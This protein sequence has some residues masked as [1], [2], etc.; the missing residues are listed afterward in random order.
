MAGGR[1]R[2]RRRLGRKAKAAESSSLA[3][4]TLSP[5]EVAVVKM[6]SDKACHASGP[7]FS[8]SPGPNVWADLVDSLLHEIILLFGSFHDFIGFVGTCRSWHHAVSSFASVYTFSFPPLHLKPGVCFS[9]RQHNG[10]AQYMLLSDCK[11]KISDPAKRDLTLQCS[12]PQSTHN[13]MLYMGS[14][15]GYLIFFH[16]GHSL[17]VNVYTGTEVKPPIL[18]YKSQL[19]IYCGTLMAP[20]N[21]SNLH[22]LLFTK[23]TMYQWQIGTDSWSEQRLGLDGE[24]FEQIVFFKGDMFAVDILASVFIIH[25]GPQL[26]T[27]RVQVEWNMAIIGCVVR[28]WLVV[29]GDMILVVSFPLNFGQSKGMSD[30]SGTFHVFRFDLSVQPAQLVEME[31]LENHALFISLDRR[32][33]TFSCW[34]PERWGGKSN[35]IYV[36]RQLEDSDEPWTAV[37]L[38]Q[39]VHEKTEWIQFGSP[40]YPPEFSVHC[41]KLESLWMLPN[42]V[43]G[44]DQ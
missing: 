34:R 16:Q 35:C 17:L 22:L 5:R 24:C 3:P 20:H 9:P 18:P 32:N 39:P 30:L 42:F 41:S 13:Q 8:S 11:W 2:R 26:S 10:R 1:Q 19:S 28:P 36:A 29:C 23:G 25:F 40:H 7:S 4:G 31:K 43:S 21:S 27:Q 38:G 37:E 15:C 12:V 6:S 33:P 14:S 44:A